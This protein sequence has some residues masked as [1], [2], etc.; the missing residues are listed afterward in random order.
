MENLLKTPQG[1]FQLR[2]LPFRKNE[3]LRAWDAAD[4]YLLNYLAED[5]NF[6]GKLSICILNDSFGALAVAL[7]GYRPT[8]ISDSFLSQQATRLNLEINEIPQNNVQLLDSLSP[9]G[10]FGID[11]ILIK[12]P[13]SLAMLEDQLHRLRPFLKADSKLL[14]AGMVKNLP[15]SLWKLL[16]R[17]IGPTST[18]LAVKKAKLITVSVDSSIVLADNP[19]PVCYCLENSDYRI[20]NRCQ[21]FFQRQFRYWYPVLASIFAG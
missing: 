14:L 15:G 20:F 17:M 19:Y 13:K 6:A 1:R 21:C 5:E 7:H 2:R 9:P 8:V 12:V 11:Y 10:I 3:L 4:E 18:A 16:E